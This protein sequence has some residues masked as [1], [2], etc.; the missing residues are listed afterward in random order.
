MD[1]VII[2]VGEKTCVCVTLSVRVL[3][4]HVDPDHGCMTRISTR[5]TNNLTKLNTTTSS[6]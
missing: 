4:V 3:W 2:L 1:G 5:V 6:I